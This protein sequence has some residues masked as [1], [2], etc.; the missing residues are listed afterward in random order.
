MK[1]LENWAK[2]FNHNLITACATILGLI[3]VGIIIYALFPENLDIAYIKNTF[4][5]K[6]SFFVDEKA[7]RLTY[8][9]NTLLFLPLF[10]LFY[11]GIKKYLKIKDNIKFLN[12]FS[13][14]GTIL[15]ILVLFIFIPSSLHFGVKMPLSF[16]LQHILEIIIFTILSVSLYFIKDK[17]MFENQIFTSATLICLAIYIFKILYFYPTNIIN[18]TFMEAYHFDAF[19]YPIFK[20]QQGLLPA[21]DFKNIYGAYPYFYNLFAPLSTFKITFLTAIIFFVSWVCGIFYI[22]KITKNKLLAFLLSIVFVYLTGGNYV[23]YL[24]FAP[25]RIIAFTVLLFLATLYTQKQKI[26]LIVLGFIVSILAIIWN[27]ETGIIN[28]IAWITFICYN[29]FNNYTIKDKKLFISSL[30]YSFYGFLSFCLALLMLKFIPYF[31]GGKVANLTDI[32]FAQ[33]LY[34]KTGFM[35][36]KISPLHPWFLHLLIYMSALILALQPILRTEKN[37]DKQLPLLVFLSV[38]GLGIYTYYQGRSSFENLITVFFPALL[39]IPIYFKKY[40]TK[41]LIL[42]RNQLKIL[43]IYFIFYILLSLNLLPLVQLF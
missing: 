26:Y 23:Y 5:N 20:I 8:I 13:A 6:L 15:T 43:R 3:L 12:N 28:L 25:L 37:Q 35:V 40:I 18:Q 9:T 31:I 24:Q 39:I 4:T 16:I 38:F 1:N 19:V 27:F 34:Y 42:R 22:Y 21:I 7:E 11:F 30:K 41:Y 29:L 14:V 32:L 17:K 2:G 10:C 33:S 36:A